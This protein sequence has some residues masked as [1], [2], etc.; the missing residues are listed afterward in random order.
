MH[1]YKGQPCCWDGDEYDEERDANDTYNLDITYAA[2]QRGCSSV[3]LVFVPTIGISNINNIN[4]YT[5]VHYYV[6]PSDLK[7]IMFNSTKG[8]IKGSFRFVKKGAN[9][10]LQLIKKDE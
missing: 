1:F 6:F 9:Y 5:G 3:L 4:D 8:R 7:A 2:Y 10:G